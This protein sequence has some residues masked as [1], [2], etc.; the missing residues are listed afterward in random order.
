MKRL[1]K[2]IFAFCLVALIV[3]AGPVPN[4]E[5]LACAG[6]LFTVDFRAGLG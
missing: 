4:G 3:C 5:W 1:L 6:G 2:L